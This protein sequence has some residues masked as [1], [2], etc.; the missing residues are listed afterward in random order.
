MLASVVV[1]P[2]LA[3][4]HRLSTCDT[5][6]AAPRQVGSSWTRDGTHDP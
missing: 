6:L 5:D 2:S 1:A 3:L 4:E